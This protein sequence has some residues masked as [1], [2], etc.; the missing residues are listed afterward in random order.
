MT[1][2]SLHYLSQKDSFDFEIDGM[3]KVFQMEMKERHRIF[4][5]IVKKYEKDIC[6]MLETNATCFEV[7]VPRTKWCPPMGYEVRDDILTRMVEHELA[8]PADLSKER[9]GTYE[10]KSSQVHETLHKAKRKR[11]VEKVIEE[12]A[13]K[14]GLTKEELEQWKE[15]KA[16]KIETGS[17]APKSI[18]DD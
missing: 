7:V 8:A 10:E 1:Q 3:F 15:K 16:T 5:E 2:I 4:Y 17:D 11:K 9:W 14:A 13:T 12:S 6:F 18:K